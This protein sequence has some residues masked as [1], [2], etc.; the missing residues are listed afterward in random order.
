[1][2]TI[3][4]PTIRWFFPLALLSISAF[5]VSTMADTTSDLTAPGVTNDSA[6][7]AQLGAP[8]TAVSSPF[9][10]TSANGLGITGTFSGTGLLGQQGTGADDLDGNFTP[11]DN[12]ILVRADSLTLV[13][14]EGISS[15]GAQIA[16]NFYG[17]FTGEIQAYNGATLL[18]SYTEAGDSTDSDDGTAIFLGLADLTAPDITSVVFSY[19]AGAP[20][21]FVLDTLDLNDSASAVGVPEPPTLSLVLLGLAGLMIR[22]RRAL[23]N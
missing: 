20:Q 12:L 6:S 8:G 14:S 11:G 22:R 7:W 5:A 18:G 9:T 1:M 10:L 23:P 4:L 13:F 3:G 17:P 16:S 19:T 2:R 21:G 15:V